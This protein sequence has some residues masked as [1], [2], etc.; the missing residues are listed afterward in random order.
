VT[1][2]KRRSLREREAAALV[3][4]G[5]PPAAAPTGP[6]PR[7]RSA[8]TTRTGDITR[9]GTYW[10][11]H[12]FEGAKSAYLVDLDQLRAAPDS[13]ARWVD[14]A[15]RRHADLTPEKR[16]SLVRKLPAEA[17][18]AA[19]RSFHVAAATVDAME[20]AIVDD[21]RHGRILSRTEFVS[22][23]VRA[24]TA[25]AQKRYG[26]ELP[27]APARLPNRPPRSGSR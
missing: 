13:F 8:P 16:A 1:P 25:D 26:G 23:A 27:P 12:T 5:Q 9:L 3:N 24:A 22:E 4:H 21:R 18:D 14:R 10:R 19:S 6:P 17:G 15:I 11:L 7:R 2:P 20:A